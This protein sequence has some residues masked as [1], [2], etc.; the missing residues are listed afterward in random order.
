[1]TEK[2]AYVASNVL[3][4]FAFDVDGEL[5]GRVDYPREPYAISK[6]MEESLSKL[7]EAKE[8]KKKLPDYECIFDEGEELTGQ[9][10]LS[11]QLEDILGTLKVDRGH[12]DS[13]LREV[14]LLVAKGALKEAMSR[15]D[16]LLIQAVEAMD[17]LDEALNILTERL[18][19]WYSLHFPE[20][21]RKVQDQGK[22]AELISAHGTRGGFEAINDFKEIAESSV[23]VELKDVDI[24]ALKDFATRIEETYKFRDTLEGYI[25]EKMD[26]LAPNTTALA[27]PLVGGKLISLAGGVEKLAR[28]PASRIQVLGAQKAMY[29]HLKEKGLPPK[30]GIIFQHPLVKMAPWWQRGRISRS[31]AAKIAIAARVDAFSKEYVAEELKEKLNARVEDIRKTA[32]PKKMRIIRRPVEPRQNVKR[33]KR[34]K[35]GRK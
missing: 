22:Y 18:R 4:L 32:K 15:E 12:Y 3:G 26:D 33:K 8:L 34:R 5:V 16:L 20:L 29:R 10:F 11:R 23:G 14:S 28:M 2:K 7:A 19:E 24:K 35:R 31:F 1:M 13:L 9:M 21:S 30:H 27:G 17:D 25:A 6:R